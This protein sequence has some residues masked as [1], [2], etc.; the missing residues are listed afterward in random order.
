MQQD[1]YLHEDFP[2][3]TVGFPD[4]NDLLWILDNIAN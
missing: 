3:K 2:T 4:F 1:D